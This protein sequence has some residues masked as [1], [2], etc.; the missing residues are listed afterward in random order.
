[1][2]TGEVR[3]RRS[4]RTKRIPN[5]HAEPIP[6][7]NGT[8][9][10]PKRS[11]SR[12]K[13][14]DLGR[15]VEHSVDELFDARKFVNQIHD[16]QKAEVDGGIL[17]AFD[18]GEGEKLERKE[19]GRERKRK[20]VAEREQAIKRRKIG[21]EVGEKEAI[22]SMKRSSASLLAHVGF[23]GVYGA[24]CLGVWCIEIGLM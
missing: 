12:T 15:M 20:K 10:T 22:L 24:C 9:P 18:D 17:P 5:G 1:M 2:E 3:P 4:S 16:F 23:E 14:A 13:K 19:L 7:G 11:S 21:G 6:N 8:A